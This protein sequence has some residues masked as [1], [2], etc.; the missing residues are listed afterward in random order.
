MSECLQKELPSSGL[1]TN[2][3]CYTSEWQIPKYRKWPKPPQ[4]P[5]YISTLSHEGQQYGQS[6]L[7]VLKAF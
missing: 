7:K 4:C 1:D 6:I 2:P 5:D 3:L